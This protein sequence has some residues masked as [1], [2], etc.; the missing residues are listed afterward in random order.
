VTKRPP[1]GGKGLSGVVRRADD[2]LNPAIDILESED[3]HV[4]HAAGTGRTAHPGHT[5]E[6]PA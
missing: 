3:P 5:E 1:D 4:A 6:V 2:Y